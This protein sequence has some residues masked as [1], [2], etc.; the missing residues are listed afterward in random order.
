LNLIANGGPEEL[1][2]Q[3]GVSGCTAAYA[4]WS[5]LRAHKADSHKPTCLECGKV[6]TSNQN[7]K[8]H[9]DTHTDRVRI[10]CTWPECDKDYANVRAMQIHIERFHEKKKSFVCQREGC[11][12]MYTTKKRLQVHDGKVHADLLLQGIIPDNLAVK[13]RHAEVGSTDEEILT[14]KLRLQSVQSDSE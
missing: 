6:L 10:P 11:D 13:R 8:K 14:R 3:C 2:Y 7:L 1:V 4:K 5:L 12:K 9:M